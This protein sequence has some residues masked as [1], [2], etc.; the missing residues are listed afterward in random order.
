MAFNKI[1]TNNL[2]IQKV[3]PLNRPDWTEYNMKRI[4]T[5][6]IMK[7]RES[8]LGGFDI[9]SAIH[10][11][12]EHL[13]VKIF[14]IK[15]DEVNDNGDAFS[16]SELIK[17][18]PSFVGVP[19]FCNHQNDDIEKA[20]GI[21]A[22]AWYDKEM[23]GI[24]TIARV[25]R[26]AWPDLARGIEQEIVTGSSMG[27]TR[28]NDLV[29]MGDGSKKKVKELKKG[30]TVRTHTGKKEQIEVVCKTQEHDELYLVKWNGNTKGLALSHE[31][32]LLA[33]KSEDIYY[34]NKS[35]KLYRKTPSEIRDEIKP[36]FIE[37][38]SIKPGDYVLEYVPQKEI[39]VDEINDDIAFLL[40]LY[41]AEGYINEKSVGFCLGMQ[42]KESQ[43]YIKLLDVLKT[44]FPD[45]KVRIDEKL[46]RNGLYVVTWNEKLAELC[47][48]Y[49]GRG[50]HD[51]KLHNDVLLLPKNQQKL[52]LGAYLDGDGCSIKKR[53]T[54]NGQSSG[55]GA[56]QASSA[57]VDLLSGMRIIC[58]RLGVSAC[59]SK[60][61]RT[62]SS[63]TVM[64]QSTQYVEYMLYMTN[65]IS[66]VLH[67]YSSKAHNNLKA[68]RTKSDS[69][70]YDCYMAHKIKNVEIISNEET[71]YYVQVGKLDDKNSDHSYIINDIAT[72]NCSVT[73]SMCSICH[74]C[75]SVADEYCDCVKHRKNKKF[76]GKQKC[77][78]HDSPIKIEGHE[79]TCPICGSTSKDSKTNEHKEAQIYEHNF[80]IKF[81]EDSFVVNPAC[82]DCLVQEIFNKTGMEQKVASLKNRI[83]K[84]AES[85]ACDSG[86]CSIDGQM[87]KV[88]GKQELDELVTAMDIVEKVAKSLMAQKEYVSMEYVSDLVKTLAEMQSISDELTE[89][90]Y[91]QIPSPQLT[92]AES[93]ELP[94]E[95]AEPFGAEQQPLPG[96]EPLQP[97][98]PRQPSGTQQSDMSGLGTVTVP[99]ISRKKEDFLKHSQILIEKF[100][101]LSENL[102]NI[103]QDMLS[104]KELNMADTKDSQSKDIEKTAGATDVITEKQLPDKDTG[105]GQQW[106]E[107]LDV[108]TEKQLNDPNKHKDAGLTGKLPSPQERTGSYE[109]ITEKQ[110][111]S[112]TADYV[113]RWG[114]Y[115]EVITE[116]QW[117]EMSRL[118]GSELSKDQ[119]DIIT[120]K[121]MGDFLSHHRYTDWNVV[122]EKQ[123]PQQDGDLARWA[124]TFDPT[125]VVKLAMDS[126]S[127]TIAFYNKTPAEVMKASA[128]INDPKNINKAAMLVLVNA[129]PNKK[130]TIAAEKSK[131]NYFSKLA[132]SSVETP[133]AVDALIASMSSNLKDISADDLIE[134]SKH[135]LSSEKGL[136][137]AEESAKIK[138]AN[139]PSVDEVVSKTAQ[140]DSAINEL[141]REEDG[142]YQIKASISEIG[143]DITNKKA[144]VEATHKFA[145]KQIDDSDLK[146]A[147][148]N[149]DVDEKA[150][151]VVA[152]VK[153]INALTEE[154][155]TSV[156]Q[157]KIDSPKKPN[158]FLPDKKV[159]EEEVV[160]SSDPVLASRQARR[161]NWIEEDDT[162]NLADSTINQLELDE[163][164]KPKPRSRRLERDFPGL[165][166]GVRNTQASRQARRNTLVKEAQM[167]GG[168]MGGQGG[169]AQGP[170]A[171]ATLPNAGGDPMDQAPME[172]FENSDLGDDLGGT[173][174]LMP[175]P[176]GSVCPVCTSQ[177]VDIIKG[178]GKCNNCQSEFEYKVSINVTRWADVLGDSQDDGIEEDSPI[179]VEGFELPEPGAMEEPV[180][181]TAGMPAMANT[182]FAAM[183]K[184]TKEAATKI[185]EAGIELGS[186]SPFTGTTQT[187]K[188]ADGERKCLDT[189]LSYKVSYAINKNKP[190]VIYAQWEWNPT[191][192]DFECNDCSRKKDM[193]IKALASSDITE[194]GFDALSPKEKG[195]VILAMKKSGLTKT[196]S[197]AKSAISIYKQSLGPVKDFPEEICKERIAR[198]Y[199]L[200]AVA[201]SGPYE[202]E[203]LCDAICK[204]L[205]KAEVY[206]NYL[207]IKVADIWCDKSGTEECIEDY[208]REGF[209]LKQASTICQ[210]MKAKYAQFDD[211]V[212]DEIGDMVEEDEGFNGPE[213][214]FDGGG[215]F[216]GDFDPFE[217]E[218]EDGG[219]ATVTIE[220]PIEVAEQVAEAVE[221]ATG[222]GDEIDGIDDGIDEGVE[223]DVEIEGPEGIDGADDIVEDATDEIVDD[224]TD[225][226]IG[227]EI[228]DE[229]DDEEALEGEIIEGEEKDMSA[230]GEVCP[231][232]GETKSMEPGC[233]GGETKPMEMGSDNA[234]AP[235]ETSDNVA[236]VEDELKNCENNRG[237]EEHIENI[238][239]RQ[240][241][242]GDPRTVADTD[243]D[244]VR[245]SNQMSKGHINKT[246]E[247]N[248]DLS[249]VL[250]VLNKSAD[251]I[252]LQNAQDTAKDYSGNSTIGDESSFTADKPSAP[253]GTATMGDE[254]SDLQKLDN[255]SA[256]TKD[257]RIGGE[258][259]D[260]TLKPELDNKATGGEEGAGNA[261]AASTKDRVHAL[262]DTLVKNADE[263]KVKREQ[264]Q[265]DEDVKPYSGDS[266]IGNEKESIGDIPEAKTTPDGIPEDNDF[267]GNEQESIGDKPD[268]VKD[269]PDI[270][271][272]DDR[273]GGEKDNEKIAPE[274]EDQMTG[275]IDSGALA[276]SKEDSKV[277]KEAYALAGRMLQ[278]GLIEVGQLATKVAELSAYQPS[279]L[280]DLEK[281]MFV[282]KGLDASSDGLEGPAVLISETSTEK[283]AQSEHVNPQDELTGKL[284]GLFSLDIRNKEADSIP[285]TELRQ[286]YGR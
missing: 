22:H 230:G 23:G 39:V 141:G 178:A 28:G 20:R 86:A 112:V 267:I 239:E 14:A 235:V 273:I 198:R 46:E 166:R 281:G 42:D 212:S 144:F 84:M 215:D 160:D 254:S 243:E 174:D 91:G 236:P 189:G 179:E 217:G 163:T 124:Y 173:E 168:E 118:V 209:Q 33:I 93:I 142:L 244:I 260:P 44:N 8:D 177:D 104:N 199:G 12:P 136:K 29:L 135:V 96:A 263:K 94:K 250:A 227:D 75:A 17:A 156:A 32:P 205:K 108:T 109:V 90:G 128:F 278:S 129:M 26:V 13:F 234:E 21:I 78:Y 204:S 257:D 53:T 76:S 187:V 74:N 115:P 31:H 218:G 132:S 130:E 271:T 88:A 73:S 221:I 149:I 154:E 49:V 4:K 269:T 69:F 194:A 157:F 45:S 229:I 99:K 161:N 148:T 27:A 126:V 207:A 210:T 62:A 231:H 272:K 5:A 59:L 224:V 3:D 111:N 225:G 170:G 101:K 143:A 270:P 121:Q 213:D 196:A 176:P 54:K 77:L 138:L 117:T 286:K 15:K 255:A 137:Q 285:D 238:Q 180:A 262:A 264:V 116:K 220:L 30:D 113:A 195:N 251:K 150:G 43:H 280:A 35:K 211:I 151:I 192:L 63:S 228:I 125:K 79:D 200:D 282:K 120:E 145:D 158:P 232:C 266:F 41:A 56:M 284:Q 169:A 82:H 114:D 202:G 277:T 171:G 152:T 47:D 51:K 36:S 87:K 190:E 122:T 85:Q 103:S 147:I 219:E 119:D 159:E 186:V 52:I 57:S 60:H 61:E 247:I 185:S 95:G 37:S 201:L 268:P 182:N 237:T 258:K 246:N 25:D 1:A 10:K 162:A 249:G 139:G 89:M 80:G 165:A 223:V 214:E 11:H 131:Y 216:D 279:Q 58:M 222:G 64:D 203:L 226:V 184:I 240:F 98:A 175:K 40:G 107:N 72:H 248:M 153:D 259:D 197:S 164:G 274:K 6:S 65:G 83:V 48:K 276:S 110:F 55:Q 70:I 261:K 256:P 241:K 105:A 242:E 81:I 100:N 38:R 67:K 123:L 24:Y 71:T 183:A 167:M 206:S 191:A 245:E 188:L 208:V 16:E 252:G 275:K 92:G 140:F 19:V 146:T 253:T 68:I 102:T 9:G 97:T 133:N 265:D 7:N 106:Q 18:T 181:E 66:T 134:G 50:S 172:S 34:T 283:R 193:F 127:D 2:T 233:C 155:K